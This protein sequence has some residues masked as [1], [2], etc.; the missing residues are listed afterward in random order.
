[1]LEAVKE[2][3]IE[4]VKR[5]LDTDD[6]TVRDERLKPIYEKVH[7]HFDEIYPEQRGQDRRVHV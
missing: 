1:M 6:K 3:A 2:F 7:E 5:A 4:D